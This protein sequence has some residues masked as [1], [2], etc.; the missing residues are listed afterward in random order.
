M[1]SLEKYKSYE[2]FGK[3]QLFEFIKAFNAFKVD[4]L[5]SPSYVN[6]GNGNEDAEDEEI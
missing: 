1:V 2:H 5:G 4:F 3:E 6:H